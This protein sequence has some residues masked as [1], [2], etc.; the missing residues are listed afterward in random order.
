MGTNLDQIEQSLT[1]IPI[2]S[3]KPTC[4]IANT[5]KG[6]GVSLMEDSYCDITARQTAARWLGSLPNWAKCIEK[7]L[8]SRSNG[9]GRTRC[10]PRRTVEQ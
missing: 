4:V 7:R 3:G 2:E 10:S 9:I 8:L 1:M 5:V 6:K